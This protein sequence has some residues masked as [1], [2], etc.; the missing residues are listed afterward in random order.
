MDR[1]H[2]SLSL[3]SSGASK[4][5]KRP[6]AGWNVVRPTPHDRQRRILK[7]GKK[8]DQRYLGHGSVI[9][10]TQRYV[11]NDKERVLVECIK[12][13]KEYLKCRERKPTFTQWWLNILKTS[14]TVPP[15]D[16]E[17]M[18]ATV[19]TLI[20]KHLGFHIFSVFAK[21]QSGQKR[22]WPEE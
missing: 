9:D 11:L 20:G 22:N 13:C 3:P 14:Q 15:L 6:L 5:V 16:R 19:F 8:E 10:V 21:I 17:R 12:V 4:K 18:S 7:A 1:K 2:L